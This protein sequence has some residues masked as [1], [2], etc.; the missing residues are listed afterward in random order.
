MDWTVILFLNEKR[1]QICDKL[2]FVDRNQHLLTSILLVNH[3]DLAEASFT[4]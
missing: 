2:L 4:K 1:I 3:L